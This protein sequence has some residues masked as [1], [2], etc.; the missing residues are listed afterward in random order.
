MRNFMKIN[1]LETEKSFCRLL[2]LVNHALV[3]ILNVANM[4]FKGIHENIIL[5]NISGLSVQRIKNNIKWD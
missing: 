3:A 4:S 1:S 2:I 5:A